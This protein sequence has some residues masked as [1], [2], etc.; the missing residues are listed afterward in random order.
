MIRPYLPEDADALVKIWLDASLI[1]H[2]FVPAAYWYSKQEDMRTLY[3]PSSR[4]W[5]YV[6]NTTQEPEGFVS[7]TG[8][9][10]AAIFVTPG[11]QRK[12]IGKALI[13]QV[14]AIYQEIT[15]NVYAENT[16]SVRFYEQQGFVVADKGTEEGTGRPELFMRFVP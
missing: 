5:V 12:G 14:K 16:A 2:A 7:M 11:K 1:A 8:H 4:T 13:D 15:L 6:N 9:H 3:L 10:L